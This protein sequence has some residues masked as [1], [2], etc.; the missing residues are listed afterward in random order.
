MPSD[1]PPVA[2]ATVDAP[3]TVTNQPEAHRVLVSRPGAGTCNA[4]LQ[5]EDGSVYAAQVRFSKMSGPCGCYLGANLSGP[6]AVAFP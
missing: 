5:L 3:C 1:L 6:A 4:R 2:S